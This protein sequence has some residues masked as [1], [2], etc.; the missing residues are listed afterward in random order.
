MVVI[1]TLAALASLGLTIAAPQASVS[2]SAVSSPSPSASSS[3]TL[4]TEETEDLYSLHEELVNIPSI[5]G[6]E[7]ECAE[8]ISKYLSDLGYYVE[9]IPAG[10]TGTFNVFAYPQD[11]KD[12]GVWPE[13]LI[14][15][16]IDTVPPFYPFERKEENG[17]VY[18]FGRGSVDAKGPVATMIIASHKLFQ[19]RT[20][21]PSLGM[22]FVVAEETGGAG[23]RAFAEY[24]SNTTF[25]AGIF[26]EPTEGKLASGHKGYLGV[27]LD[28]TGRSSHSAYPWL[29]VSA[30]NYLAEAIVGLNML[31]PALPRSELLGATTLNAGIVAGGVASNVVPDHANASIAVRIAR[32]EDD[33]VDL[34]QDMIAGM[35]SPFETRAK[36]ENATFEVVFSNARYPAVILDTDVEG[37]EVAPVFFGTDIPSLPQVD[38]KYL[39]GTGTIEV[40]HTPD[41]M[42]SQDELVQAAE[43]YGMILESLF[44]E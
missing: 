8:F 6:D 32:S 19:S 42:L 2:P 27:S 28:I 18:H 3:A 13:V 25:R 37:L 31:E 43:A 39:F 41:E 5:S 9:E 10:D 35:L 30:I 12:E 40:A 11:L 14:T 22:L 33:A 1:K 29:G 17:T 20:D 7:V 26:G 21:T 15:S 44:S 36:E 16:H 24:A 23:M 38:K 34:V 4:T